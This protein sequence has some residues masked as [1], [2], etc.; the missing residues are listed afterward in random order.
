M[1]IKRLEWGKTL[2]TSNYASFLDSIERFISDFWHCP[3]SRQ[4]IHETFKCDGH[5]HCMDAT[6]ETNCTAGETEE[7]LNEKSLNT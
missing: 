3:E 7:I 2:Y 6:D 5:N 4:C 1:R